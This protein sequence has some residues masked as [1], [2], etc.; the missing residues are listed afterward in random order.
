M[1]AAILS[2]ILVDPCLKSNS[3]F[4]KNRSTFLEILVTRLSL[5]APSGNVNKAGVFFKLTRLCLVSP[6]HCKTKTTNSCTAASISQFWITGQIAHEYHF[7][8]RSHVRP[9][10]R[11]LDIIDLIVM[12][13][14]HQSV[15]HH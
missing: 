1:L 3:T 7:I 4:D 11:N 2:R 8:K 13:E 15:C 5:L 10:F 14:F 6:V 12:C 9:S